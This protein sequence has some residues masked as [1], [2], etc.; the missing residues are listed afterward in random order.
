MSPARTRCGLLA[1]IATAALA[2]PVQAEFAGADAPER[3]YLPTDILVVGQRDGY[4]TDDGSTGTK[5]PTPLIDVPQSIAVITRD[6][7]DDQAI[8]Q[9]SEALRYVPGVS[10]ETGEGNRDQVFV[11]GQPSTAD[12]YL[13]GLRDDAQYYR[14][15]YNVE[16]IEVLKGANALIFGRGGGGGAINR[17]S[18]QAD[19]VR[20]MTALAAQVDQFGAFALSGDVNRPV[21][22]GAGVRLNAAYEEFASNRDFFDGRFIG[23]T[24][25]VAL[26][27][28]TATRLT[29]S[30]TYDDDRR[31]TDRGNPSLNGRPLTGFDDTLFGDRD[32]NDTRSQ[33]HIARAR[34]DHDF[35][36]Q[37]SANATVQF[38]DYDKYYA[39]VLPASATATTVRLTGYRAA[40]QRRNWIGQANLVWQGDTG[41]LGHTLLFGVEA[42]DQDNAS[43]RQEAVFATTGGPASSVTVPLA[44]VLTLPAVSLGATTQRRESHLSVLSGYVQ[45]QIAVSDKLQLIGGVRWER[46]DLETT[47]LLTGTPG[48]RV[49]TF[50]SPRLGLVFKPRDQISLYLS[51]SQ[52][53]LPQAGDQFTILSPGNAAFAPETFDNYEIGGKWAIRP[54]LFLSAAAFRLDRGNTRAPDPNNPGVTVLTGSTRVEGFELSLAGKITPDWQANLAYTFLDGEVRSTTS[55][56]A[57]GNRLAQLPKSQLSLWNRVAV[58]DRFALGLG[59][60]HQS[61]QFAAVDNTVILP[62][63]WRVDAAAYLDLSDRFALQLNLENLFDEDYFASAHGNNNIQPGEPLTV[64]AGVRVKL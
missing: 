14:P 30:Y 13:D 58:T 19:A 5:T 34:I 18:K 54:D 33:A 28:G 4:A 63:Y 25:A 51:Y 48:N 3:E 50:W 12:F 21:A 9:L 40:N 22:N 42:I 52:S 15:L 2:A 53:F 8:T 49:D 31:L 56:A 20:T 41:P 7:L 38:A 35:S 44:R 61:E 43:N 62:S 47:D 45:D 32:F 26:D 55:A 39:N 1:A 37:L 24:P 16:R 17:V 57:A 6:Q 36:G 46:F 23:I 10:L 29:A 59:V 64:R 27:L 60:I 11:R